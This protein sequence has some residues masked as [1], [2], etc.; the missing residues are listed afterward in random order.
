MAFREGADSEAKAAQG[1]DGH[2]E[3]PMSLWQT[4]SAFANTEGGVIILGAEEMADGSLDLIGVKDPA[5]VN[6]DLWNTLNNRQKV[7]ANLLAE[8]DIEVVTGPDNPVVV[9][10]VPRASRKDRPVYVNGNPLT[11]TYRRNFDGDYA[12]PETVIRR[13]LA[14]AE[15]DSRDGRINR[16]VCGLAPRLG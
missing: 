13:M 7:S 16:A 1:R 9:M 14:E 11:G 12:C 2:G 4:Y 5:R 10:R 6:R 8:R 15:E 3:V